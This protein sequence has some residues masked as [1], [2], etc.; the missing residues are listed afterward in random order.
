MKLGKSRSKR[1]KG[2]STHRREVILAWKKETGINC[3]SNVTPALHSY[4]YT[5]LIMVYFLFSYY[6][7]WFTNVL[8]RVFA[9][10]IG[11]YFVFLII[12]LSILDSRLLWVHKIIQVVFLFSER[13][14]ACLQKFT[15]ETTW[16]WYFLLGNGFNVLLN[17]LNRHRTIQIFYFFPCQIWKFTFL[18]N[19][20]IHLNV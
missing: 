16:T 4:K 20:F 8:L 7:I 6:W 10:V 19:V 12:S 15:C 18:R 1:G 3:F 17:F 2:F 11:M 5:N 9:S 14:Y 13:V